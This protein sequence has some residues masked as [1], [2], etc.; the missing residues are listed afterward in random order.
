MSDE[1]KSLLLGIKEVQEEN[2][3][4][5]GNSYIES[6]YVFTWPD[7][8]L[9]DIDYVTRK[10]AQ[11]LKKYHLKKVRFH[12]LRHSCASILLSAGYELKDVQEQLGHSEIS[13]TADIYGH[14][15]EGR[16]RA[17]ADAM[18]GLIN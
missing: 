17:L 4:L 8:H 10:F 16:K 3:A 5:F 11:L 9:I 13:I 1:I 6:D 15:D 14:L 18:A 7:G 12:D 2:R